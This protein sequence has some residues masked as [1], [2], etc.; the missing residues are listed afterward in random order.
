[1]TAFSE[2]FRHAE[3]GIS[4]LPAFNREDYE[5]DGIHLNASAGPE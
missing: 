1:M 2:S 4:V 5:R 3:E